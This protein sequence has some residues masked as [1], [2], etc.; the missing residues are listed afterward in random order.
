[1]VGPPGVAKSALCASL[2]GEF[3]RLV[4]R[5]DLGA[6]LGS[7]VGE[8]QQSLRQALKVI[9]AVAGNN[10]LWV[11]TSNSINGLDDA[12]RSRLSDVFFFDLPGTLQRKAIWNIWTKAYD[13]KAPAKMIAEIDDDG[14]AGRNIQ[15]CCLNAWQTGDAITVS[16]QSVVP[17]A[18]S[19][20]EQIERL[21]ND[22]T[23]RYLC[24]ETGRLYQRPKLRTNHDSRESEV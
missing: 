20:R 8:S 1:M 19:S 16:A 5:L 4:T 10:A 21:R 14:W 23:G 11:V 18:V 2:S 7:L 12:L 6:M 3:G 24:A 13:L 17:V 9:S 15:R 22:A